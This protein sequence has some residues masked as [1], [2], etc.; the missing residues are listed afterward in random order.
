MG[1]LKGRTGTGK[2]PKINDQW[3]LEKQE[4]SAVTTTP[5][6]QHKQQPTAPPFKSSKIAQILARQMKDLLSH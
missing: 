3:L 4:P 2:T 1:T 5:A 6:T